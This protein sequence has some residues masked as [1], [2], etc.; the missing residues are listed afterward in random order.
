MCVCAWVRW[1]V[2]ARVRGCAGACV[3]ALLEKRERAH[4]QLCTLMR[5]KNSSSCSSRLA[6]Q[7]LCS[8]RLF[9]LPNSEGPIR[10]VKRARG[11]VCTHGVHA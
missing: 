11:V 3:R 2:G 1:C 4:M 5:D 7:K 8:W 6:S 10:G 9:V